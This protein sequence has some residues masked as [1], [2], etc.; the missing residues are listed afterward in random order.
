M[1]K[2]NF[3]VLTVDATAP[4]SISTATVVSAR[5]LSAVVTMLVGAA[6]LFAVGFSSNDFAHAAAHDVRHS[7]GFPCH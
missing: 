1:E 4:R 6:I 5:I 3:G 2:V 7:A